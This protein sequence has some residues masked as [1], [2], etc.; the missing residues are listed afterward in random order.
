MLS[1]CHV[2]GLLIVDL[3]RVSRFRV[4]LSVVDGC[5]MDFSTLR[6]CDVHGRLSSCYAFGLLVIDLRARL[7]ISGGTCYCL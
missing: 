7:P 5:G 3:L 2:F 4:G 6:F 1:S